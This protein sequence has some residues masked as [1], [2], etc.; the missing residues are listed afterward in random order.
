MGSNS[1]SN[2]G[3]NG[4]TGDVQCIDR[5][6]TA[7]LDSG[8]HNAG[9][10]CQSGCH[11]HGFVVSGTLYDKNGAAFAG[12]NIQIVDANG[13]EWDIIS[14][15]NGNFGWNFAL[16]YPATVTVSSCPD[17]TPMVMTL[18]QNMSCN[19]GGCHGGGAGKIHL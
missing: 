17:I 18:T 6:N 19:N 15:K 10:D 1:G 8:H 2:T 4:E 11:N 3:S 14:S 12:G 16:A 9:Q 7:N 5:A 13:Q